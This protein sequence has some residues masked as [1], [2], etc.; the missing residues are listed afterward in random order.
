MASELFF[1]PLKKRNRDVTM[2]LTRLIQALILMLILAMAASCAMS[3]EYTAKIFAPGKTT[4]TDSSVTKTPRFLNI[5]EDN[6][7]STAISAAT[8]FQ[9]EDKSTSFTTIK[10]KLEKTDTIQS[11]ES[12]QPEAGVRIVKSGET[13]NKRKRE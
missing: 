4:S 13:R 6:T 12:R 7:D 11:N 10:T 8:A 2:Q 9:K 1:I 5:G 3:K